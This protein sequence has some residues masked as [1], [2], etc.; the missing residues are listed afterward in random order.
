MNLSDMNVLWRTFTIR[1]KPNQ[2]RMS[3]KNQDGEIFTFG[4]TN[5]THSII[6]FHHYSYNYLSPSSMKVLVSLSTY[7]FDAQSICSRRTIKS[8]ESLQQRLKK[9]KCTESKQK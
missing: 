2:H 4:Y 1:P 8:Q 9:L 3:Y 7:Y 5:H 6:L